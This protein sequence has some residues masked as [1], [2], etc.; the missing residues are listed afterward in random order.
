[1]ARR[2][3]IKPVVPT[4]WSLAHAALSPWAQVWAL[5]QA[6][7]QSAWAAPQVIAMRLSDL[8]SSPHLWDARQQ[9]EA[10]RMVQEKMSA[11]H[12]GLSA[13]THAAAHGN[14]LDPMLAVKVASASLA[15]AHQKVTSNLSRLGNEQAKRLARKAR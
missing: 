8:S 6:L 10:S 7:W 15:P 1:M 13:A 11:W 2:P 12:S 4:P 5:Q 14:P 9:A 3:A